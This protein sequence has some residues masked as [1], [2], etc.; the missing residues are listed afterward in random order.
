[1]VSN[2]DVSTHEYQVSISGFYEL[3]ETVNNRARTTLDFAM[4]DA[5]QASAIAFS[6]EN[7]FLNTFAVIP[8]SHRGAL[9]LFECRNHAQRM[10]AFDCVCRLRNPY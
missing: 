10:I 2:A 8:G 4:R 1:M 5:A 3:K 6:P 9:D 7:L